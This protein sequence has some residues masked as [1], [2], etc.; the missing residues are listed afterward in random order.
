MSRPT[1]TQT[2]FDIAHVWARRGTCPRLLVGAVFA[3]R[4]W[5]VIA[6]GYNGAP[7]KL[8]HC[9]DAG[10]L[11][12]DGHCQ[13]ALHAEHNGIIQAGRIGV[14]LK[15]TRVFLT[16][17]PCQVCVKMLIQTGVST[18]DYWAPYNTDAQADQ[19]EVM[20]AAAG[21]PLRGP[22]QEAV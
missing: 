2:M 11:M 12:V 1:W 21:I 9:T 19:V 6:S 5:Q 14:S 10:C 17:R 16:H 7:R 3:D 4:D 13:R 22:H 15:G 18:V 8:A 20:L